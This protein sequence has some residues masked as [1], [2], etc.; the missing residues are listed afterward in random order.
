MQRPE[1]K[2]C[3]PRVFEDLY[4]YVVHQLACGKKVNRVALWDYQIDYGLKHGHLVES[5]GH[6]YHCVLGGPMVY[7]VEWES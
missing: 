3:N 5:C 2:R 1:P 7:R 6:Y 4:K